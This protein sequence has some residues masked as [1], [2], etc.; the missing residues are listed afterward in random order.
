[1]KAAEMDSHFDFIYPLDIPIKDKIETIAREVY[2]ADG[3]DYSELAEHRVREYTRLGYDR[4]P[5]CMAKTHLSISHDPTLKGVPKGFRVPFVTSALQSAPASS[6]P[7]SHNEHDARPA[8]PPS[9]LRHRY[10][11]QHRPHVGLKLKTSAFVD[12]APYLGVF[13]S[14]AEFHSAKVECLDTLIKNK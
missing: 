14:A 9:L 8:H 7:S 12:K 2:G 11:S 3:V 1:M 4:L 6:F 10:R 5:I 13:L